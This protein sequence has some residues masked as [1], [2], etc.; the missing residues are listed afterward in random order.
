M[1][2][3]PES[4]PAFE[5]IART[6]TF[7]DGF[8][9]MPVEVPGP[10]LG[11]ALAAWLGEHGT[12]TRVVEP[13]DEA[14]W[15]AIV[16]S[17]LDDAEGEGGA[18][19]AVML[20]GPRRMAPGM[21]AGLRLSNTRRDAIVDALASPLLWCG[22]AEFLNATWER[23]PD[24][25]SIRGMKHRVEARTS[26]PA[27]G[28]LWGGVVAHGAPERLRETLRAA[29]E[30]GDREV[31]ARVSV[32]LAETL[33]AAG[34]YAEAAEAIDE[35]RADAPRSG[36][37]AG[38]L[39]LLG[40]RAAY[41]MG[42]GD[43]AAAAL[44]EAEGLVGQAREASF[45][46][47]VAIARGNLLLYEDAAAARVAYDEAFAAAREGGDRRNTGVAQADSGIA[48]LALG[49]AEEALLALEAARELVREA[50]DERSEARCLMHLG[51]AH[52][53]L[54]DRRAATAAF[55][56]ALELVR[57]QGDRRGEARV[58]CHVARTYLDAGDAEKSREDASRALA[59]AR[60]ARD[61]RLVARAEAALAEAR[62]VAEG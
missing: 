32:Q 7:V 44:H 51:R 27:E 24:L 8:T 35:A 25:W 62:A 47:E 42:E 34:E 16:A 52:A 14:G 3:P 53:A 38:T 11:R 33:L 21:A 1:I 58:L 2:L 43:R 59:L 12:R 56:E 40:A 61:E 9:L 37:A 28:P 4:L 54:F 29:R 13:L 49:E 39:A 36:G 48:L 55:E 57:D 30:Q 50:G 60:E 5:R 17:V 41:A 23:A 18:H 6:L 26:A 10:D 22:T 31:V 45:V 20:L 19:H 15:R 46:A